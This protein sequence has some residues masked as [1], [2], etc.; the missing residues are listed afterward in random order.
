MNLL[1]TRDQWFAICFLSLFV[2]VDLAG[3]GESYRVY[4]HLWFGYGVTYALIALSVWSVGE[5][6]FEW[7]KPLFKAR[8]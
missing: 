8:G 4:T 7:I 2:Y 5:M 1:P 6:F 3:S